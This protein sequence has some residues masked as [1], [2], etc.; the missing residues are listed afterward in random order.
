MKMG[1][2]WIG[3]LFAL[4][5]ADLWHLRHERDRAEARERLDRALIADRRARGIQLPRGLAVPELAN[6][7]R[8]VMAKDG[9]A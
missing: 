3:D 2:M 8:E 1:V 5:E 4:A 7:I 9:N 6:H